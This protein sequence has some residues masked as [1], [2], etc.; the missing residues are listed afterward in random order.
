[1]ALSRGG[2]WCAG[3]LTVW[4]LKQLA[5]ARDFFLLAVLQ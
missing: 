1:M 3:V 4:R 5:R 2:E